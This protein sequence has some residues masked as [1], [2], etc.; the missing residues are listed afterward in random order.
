MPSNLLTADSTFPTLTK[1]QSADEKFEKITSYLYMLLEQ[2]RYSMG[3]L[4]KE[5]FNDA[6]LEEIANIIT[7]PVYVQLKD[8]EANI[9][10]L[11]VTA[12]G[13]G[14]RLNDAEGNITQL[15]ATSKSLTSR[16]SSAEGSIS[17]LQQ[18]ATSLTSRISDAEGNI[19]SLTQTVN[20]MTLSVTN[21]SAS[22][23]IRLLANG[24]QLSSQSISFSGMVTFSDLSTSGETTI[25]GDNITTGTIEAID[26]YGCTIEGSTFQSVLQ[27]NGTVGG[28]IQFCYLNTRY[29]A[30][31]IRLDDQG[32]GTE[33]ERTYRMFI[34]TNYVQGVGFAMKLQSASG[35]SVEAD[36]NVHLY[37][38]DYHN[39][40]TDEARALANLG[41]EGIRSS[42]GGYTGGQRGANF[43]LD[44]LSPK[45]FQS[46]KAPTY[47]NNYEGTIG[48]LL[49]KQLGYGSFSY[50]EKQP[51]YTNRYD[52][53]IQDLLGQ[54]VNR[55]DFSYDPENDQ[56]YSQ[57]RKQYAREGQR[58]TQ[59][60]LGAAAAASGGIPSSYAV[61]AAAQAGDY[62][63]SQMT[64]KIPE[65]YQLAYNKY[66][67]DYNMKLSD[68][69]AVQGAE[70]NDY[71]KFLNEMQQYNTNRAFDYQAWMDEYN[72]INNDLQTA[73]KLEQMDYTK[74]LN[75]LNQFNTD[76][77]FNY[78]QLLDEVNNQ[79]ARR[80]EA[81]NKALTAAELGDNS[82]LNNLGIN[83]DNNPTDYERRY[84]LAQLAAQYGDYSG[85]REL[86]I[87]PDAAALN[88][89]NTTAA[90]KSSSGGSRSSGGGGNTTPQETEMT[91]LSAQDI[92]AL[93]A[94]YGTNIDADTWSSILQSNPGITEAML[95]Q[96]GF[97]KSG[98]DSGGGNISGVTDYDSAIAYMKA[99]GVDGS[100]RSGLM[101]KSEWSR[102]KASLQ[103]YGTGGTEVKN[104]N[105]YADYIKDYCE[106]AASK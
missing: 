89:F 16:I 52:D 10:A 48:G 47:Q 42:Y 21:G 1:E 45:D 12:A 71:D 60:A 20:G 62:Y 106:Y 83:T 13:L 72:R 80:S 14:A 90:G 84:Q 23:T 97:T 101:T 4:D 58:A 11:T 70:K 5:N 76:R 49:D 25:N 18:T 96:A 69:G 54:I 35:I 105:S 32:A 82:F 38:Q 7:E 26:I 46:E 74:Y 68:L 22:S 51:E 40:T 87:N 100:V 15:T 29:V 73:S 67:N 37:K 19:S 59:D 33:Y 8:D 86:G 91:G 104:Y 66:M 95:T 75:D 61:N 88:R 31:G 50:G 78:G 56:L 99:A 53:T 77:S 79:T 93:K 6:G 102:R 2:L 63:A 41:A 65:L 55:K 57:Y 64:D 17:T 43:Y 3:N 103:Q 36:E 28:E 44:P 94:A 27:A 92:A 24:V 81:M 9:A 30:G 85:L 39:A 34:Y 98:G